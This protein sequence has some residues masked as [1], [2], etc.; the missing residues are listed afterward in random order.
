MAADESD[1]PATTK[2]T[3]A[4]PGR[5]FGKWAGAWQSVT[6]RVTPLPRSGPGPGRAVSLGSG[7]AWPE[8]A[9]SLPARR[10]RIGQGRAGR[11]GPGWTKQSGERGPLTRFPGVSRGFRGCSRG[12]R[13]LSTICAVGIYDQ[14]KTLTGF[15]GVSRSFRGCSRSFRGSHG[16]CGATRA[17]KPSG[18]GRIGPA[19]ARQAGPAPIHYQRAR[20]AGISMPGLAMPARSGPARPAGLAGRPG[21]ET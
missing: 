2:W 14:T 12:F 4:V 17:S 11:A 5:P 20:V 6:A 15:P 19:W 18:P 21:P 10:S 13:G 3:R 7:Q 8:P 16:V 9:P 1:L